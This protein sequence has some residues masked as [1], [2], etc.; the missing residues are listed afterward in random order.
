MVLLEVQDTQTY[1]SPIGGGPA[2][3]YEWLYAASA[4]THKADSAG[5]TYPAG[6]TRSPNGSNAWTVRLSAGGIWNYNDTSPAVV[7][8]LTDSSGGSVVSSH[9]N[10]CGV[11]GPKYSSPRLSEVRSYGMGPGMV[12]HM[13][14]Q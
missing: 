13:C 11:A 5:D 9:S 10:W 14:H 1:G 12:I 4:A 8:K 2:V 6:Y 7:C 3:R